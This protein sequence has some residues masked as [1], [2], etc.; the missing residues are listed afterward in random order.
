[1]Q[2]EMSVCPF[3]RQSV[4]LFPL[5]LLNRVIFDLVFLPVYGL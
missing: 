1:M 4:L 5:S 2:S 3:V